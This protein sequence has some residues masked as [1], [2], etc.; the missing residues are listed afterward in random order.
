MFNMCSTPKTTQKK[1]V[2]DKSA[3]CTVE[4]VGTPTVTWTFYKTTAKQP[5]VNTFTNITFKQ[6]KTAFSITELYQNSSF[7]L[8]TKSIFSGQQQ[9]KVLSEYLFGKMMESNTITMQITTFDLT[10]KQA[11]V[12]IHMNNTTV[13]KKAI[14]VI[15]EHTITLKGDF[16]LKHD[17]KAGE[18][19]YFYHTAVFEKHKGADGKSKTWADVTFEITFN[20]KSNCK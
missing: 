1:D 7:I 6:P 12:K 16:D 13:A 10:K 18:A 15:K 20:T 14:I 19:L 17:F 11:T 2:P 5:L 4:N 9:N 8:D 3:I